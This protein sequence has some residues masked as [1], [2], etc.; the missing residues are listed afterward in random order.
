M[1]ISSEYLRKIIAEEIQKL[2]KQPDVETREIE[3]DEY[4]DTLEKEVDMLKAL[5]IKESRL[6]DKLSKIQEAK[7]RI[8]K[9]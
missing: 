3:A 6:L 2:L 5:K 7:K 8:R 1:K 9:Y 4:G